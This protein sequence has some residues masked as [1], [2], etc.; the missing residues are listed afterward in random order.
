MALSC[1]RRGSG[2]IIGYVSALYN[3]LKGGCVE[4]GGRLLL[5]INSDRMRGMRGP[6]VAPGEV[7][8]GY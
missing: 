5:Q 4:V 3:L 8:I 2:W 6:Q 1:S 7:Q